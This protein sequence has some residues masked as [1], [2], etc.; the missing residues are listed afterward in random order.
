MDFALENSLPLLLED[1]LITKDAQVLLHLALQMHLRDLC[2][3]ILLCPFCEEQKSH[4]AISK[5]ILNVHSESRAD[6]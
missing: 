5:Q 1:G 3:A 4:A 6:L 2:F